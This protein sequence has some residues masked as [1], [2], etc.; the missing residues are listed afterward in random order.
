[1]IF[2]VNV[3]M[4]YA[5]LP[6]LERFGRVASDGFGAVEFWWPGDVDLDELVAAIADAGLDV[7]LFN[8]DEGNPDD[9]GLISDPDRSERFRAN[10]PIALEL[11]RRVGC[12]RLNALAGLRRGGL[13]YEQQLAVAVENARWAADLALDAGVAVMIE[14]INTVD[15][16]PYLLPT[17]SAALGFIESCA[18]PNIALQYDVYHAQRTEGDIVTKIR[19]HHDQIA[20]VQIA[21]SPERHE[22][23]TGEINFRF[24]FEVLAQTGYDGYVGLEYQPTTMTESSLSWIPPSERSG[25]FRPRILFGA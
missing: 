11:A 8:F 4:L 7:A 12:K 24:V 22:P 21:D 13:E 5:E 2:S 20:H 15:N 1:M 25:H 9:R 18:R 16:G 10:V 23:G 14:P 19:S 17:T 3:S 6:F